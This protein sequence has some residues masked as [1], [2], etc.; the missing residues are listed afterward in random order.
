M[1]ARYRELVEEMNTY[2]ERNQIL[3]RNIMIIDT[4]KKELRANTARTLAV[5]RFGH[6]PPV[7]NTQT[8]RQD[9]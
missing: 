7:A 3:Y 8:H 9:R 2:Q 6:R 4:M 5:V 1:R